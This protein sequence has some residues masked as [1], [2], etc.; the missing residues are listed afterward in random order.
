MVLK[1]KVAIV[2]GASAEAGSGWAV[3]KRFAAEGAKVV[4]AARRAEPLKKLAAEID[5]AWI[6][7]DV[8]RE[9][10]V[11]ALVDF[12][13]EKYGRIDVACNAAGLP[14]GGTITNAPM[15]DVREA[16]EVDYFGCV[17]FVRFVAEAMKAGGTGG[18]IILFSSMTATHMLES[19]Y[20]YACAKAAADCLVVY[21]AAEYGPLGIKVNSILPGPIRSEMSTPLWQVEGMEHA[22]NK[23]VP[24]GRLGLPEDFADACLWLAGPSFVT[25]LNLQVSG[26]NQ[27]FRFPRLSER[28]ALDGYDPTN[29][30]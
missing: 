27:I 23:D 22:W 5:G 29:A 11:K 18:S 4:V 7:C 20:P 17:Y 13:M 16:M 24:L 15:A 25:G 12:A 30:A 28:P 14:M 3:A 19:V 10:E 8:A 1:D 6:T 26:G 2:L 9:D 21:A